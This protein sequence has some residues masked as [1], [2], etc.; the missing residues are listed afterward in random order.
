MVVSS[1]QTREVISR[2]GDNFAPEEVI[3]QSRFQICTVYDSIL[4]SNTLLASY[5]DQRIRHLKMVSGCDLN[6]V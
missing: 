2:P 6:S 4:A 1:K 5:G 3:I